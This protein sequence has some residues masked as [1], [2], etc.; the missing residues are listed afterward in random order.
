ME[1]TVTDGSRVTPEHDMLSSLNS[2]PVDK[3]LP[4]TGVLLFQSFLTCNLLLVFE[5]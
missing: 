2:D 1:H 5:R 4:K 3:V